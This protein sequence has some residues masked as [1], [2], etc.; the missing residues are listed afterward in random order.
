MRKML[1]IAGCALALS[2]CVSLGLSQSDSEQ[3][4]TIAAIAADV[5]FGTG[6]ITPDAAGSICLIDNANYKI[7]AAT[8]NVVDMTSYAPADNAH[9]TLQTDGHALNPLKCIIPPVPIVAP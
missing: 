6:Q 8:R 9:V 1:L 2:G 4:Y 3:T 5:S 7:L